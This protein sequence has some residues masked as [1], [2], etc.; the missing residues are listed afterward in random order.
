MSPPVIVPVI[1]AVTDDLIL[2]QRGFLLRARAVMHALGARGAVHL[3]ARAV[4]GARLHAL[5][6]ALRPAAERT[7]CWLVVN[8]RLDV[9]LAAGADGVQLTS[10]SMTVADAHAVIAGAASP[11]GGR[12]IAIGASVHTSDDARIAAHAGADWCVA[13]HVFP[14]RSHPGEPPR[15]VPLISTIVQ[16]VA[17][18][19]LAIGGVRPEHLAALRAAGAHGAAAISGIWGADD[20][21]RAATDY[22]SAYDARHDEPGTPG[23]AGS[24]VAP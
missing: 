22:L 18:P 14:T 17:I 24:G 7:G 13:G 4:T 19:C 11:D 6:L 9:A 21:E 10:R 16:A 20:A 1:H 15:G 2:S 5:A 3:R 23:V 12:A 8:D